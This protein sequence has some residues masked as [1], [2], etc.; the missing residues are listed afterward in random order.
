MYGKMAIEIINV[1]HPFIDF[2]ETF[3]Q[4]KAHFMVALMLNPHFK[5]M[6][7]IMLVGI[8]LPH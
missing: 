5:G 1:L 6:D 3:C 7:C 2:V 4:D 8:K